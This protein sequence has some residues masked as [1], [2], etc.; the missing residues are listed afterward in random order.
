M[1]LKQEFAEIGMKVLF[2]LIVPYGIETEQQIGV[3]GQ[4]VHLLI[5]PYG[6][7]TCLYLRHGHLVVHF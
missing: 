7:E 5:V 2:L 6:I 3:T 1:E 4:G